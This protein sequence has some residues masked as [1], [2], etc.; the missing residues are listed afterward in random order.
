MVILF[1]SARR[2]ANKAQI[3]KASPCYIHARG[4]RPSFPCHS[5]GN[6]TSA[7]PDRHSR[8]TAE[9]RRPLENRNRNHCWKTATLPAS[10][11]VAAYSRSAP[12]RRPGSSMSAMRDVSPRL[13][14]RPTASGR[15]KCRLRRL[16]RFLHLLS[17]QW[18]ARKWQS[19]RG[20]RDDPREDRRREDR[21]WRTDHSGA[22]WAVQGQ[23][24]EAVSEVALQLLHRVAAGGVGCEAV[25][26]PASRVQ[27]QLWGNSLA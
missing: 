2:G 25:R 18:P 22:G 16:V 5:G 4:T 3:E 19:D 9:E 14:W 1:R 13:Q 6:R 24:L 10:D 23:P 7:C 27:S 20:Q 11:L 8:P 21:G 26:L 17:Q 15:A 12:A